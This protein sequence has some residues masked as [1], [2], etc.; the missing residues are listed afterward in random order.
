[1]SIERLNMGRALEAWIRERLAMEATVADFEALSTG[2][3]AQTLICRLEPTGGSAPRAF[4]LRLE[5]GTAPIFLDTDLGRQ[6]DTIRAL[7]R[8]GVPTAEVVG[9]ERDSAILGGPF[10]LMTLVSGRALPHSNF[11][12]WLYDLNEDGRGRVWRNSV[13]MLGTIN[14]LKWQDGFEML[15]KP[16]FGP[17]GLDQYLGWVSAWRE[18]VMADEPHAILDAATAYLN[19]ERPT[20]AGADVLWGDPNPGNFLFDDDQSISAV[21]DFEAAALGPG[22]IDLAWWLMMDRRR[23]LEGVLRGLPDRQEMISIYEHALGRGVANLHYF[24]VLAAF[25]MGLVLVRSVARLKSEGRLPS[26]CQAEVANPFCRMLAELL[27]LEA[28][29]V[30]KDFEQFR[31]EV[32]RQAAP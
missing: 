32:R 3:S 4:V 14:R 17:P 6:A 1:M 15:D 8:H 29:A 26:D 5:S 28:P 7:R 24:E 12:G 19:S 22:E 31:A 16:R 9:L 21:L 18:D 10:M 13:T 27:N 25:R 11:S 20:S 30:G 23:R 2:A